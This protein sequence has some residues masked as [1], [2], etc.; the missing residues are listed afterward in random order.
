MPKCPS[1]KGRGSI[2]YDSIAKRIK[3]H[4]CNGTGNVAEL[5][6]SCPICNGEGHNGIVDSGLYN[7]L[8]TRCSYCHGTGK[9]TI[10]GD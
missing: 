9:I 1:C 7:T 5:E 8:P 4:S 10:R 2:Y 6:V 3:C